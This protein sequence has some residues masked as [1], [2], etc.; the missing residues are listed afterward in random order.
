MNLTI[1][2]IVGI[3]IVWV[4]RELMPKDYVALINGSAA[5]L[6]DKLGWFSREPGTDV[7]STKEPSKPAQTLPKPKDDLKKIEGI[8][9]KI[10]EL[11]NNHGISTYADLGKAKTDKLIQILETAGSRYRIADPSTWSKQAKLAGKGDW[12]GLKQLKK[13]LKGG[14]R[15]N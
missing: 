4:I 2:F 12:D 3:I 14:R 7:E 1:S 15:K 11:L 5:S 8:G 10:A 9:P 6:I 13:E